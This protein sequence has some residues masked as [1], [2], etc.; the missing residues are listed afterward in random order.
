MVNDPKVMYTGLSED[1]QTYWFSQLQAHSLASLKAPISGASWKT[2]PSSYLLCD[3]DLAIPVQLQEM[4]VNKA[5]DIGATIE[6]SRLDTGHSPYL[7][8]PKETV[9]WIRGVAG[10]KL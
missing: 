9:G 2:I 1:E 3:Q 4:M 10:E 7:T 5:K 6:V 8:M